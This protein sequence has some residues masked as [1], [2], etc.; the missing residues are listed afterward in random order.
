MLLSYLRA[1]LTPGRRDESLE[2]WVVN[3]FGARLYRT[4]F[5]TYTEKVWG[6][7]CSAIRAEWAQQRIG[8]LRLAARCGPR[9]S[10]ARATRPSS[11]SSSTRGR[12]RG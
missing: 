8:G 1:R 7:P 9:C 11:A 6:M 5:Q 3:R 2:D 4:F 12:A 10:A